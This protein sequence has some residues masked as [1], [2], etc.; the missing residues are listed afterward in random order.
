MSLCRRDVRAIG[1]RTE[2][3]GLEHEVGGRRVDLGGEAAHHPR[4][5]DG[6]GVVGD[7][8]VLAV[9]VADDV[10]EGLQPLPRC[11]AADD[12]RTGEP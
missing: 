4:Q 7:Q 3:R 9:Q 1:N 11:G 2:V 5:S 10:V 6:T 8:H 12:D